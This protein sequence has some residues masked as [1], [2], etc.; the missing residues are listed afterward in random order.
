M[1]GAVVLV[2]AMASQNYS[3][4]P[5]PVLR[6][7]RRPAPPPDHRCRPVRRKFA[8]GLLAA[9]EVQSHP[10]VNRP[11]QRRIAEDVG[12][13]TVEKILH[14]AD[15]AQPRGNAKGGRHIESRVPGVAG[16]PQ[17]WKQEIAIRSPPDEQAGEI[18]VQTPP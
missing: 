17:R 8:Y 9:A 1:R 10:G 6:S 18:R 2:F 7:R 11:P 3:I 13:I 14:A 5:S 15:Q 12:V 4:A 16:K